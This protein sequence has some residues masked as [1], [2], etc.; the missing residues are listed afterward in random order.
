MTLRDRTINVTG[1]V[2]GPERNHQVETPIRERNR[3]G[4]SVDERAVSGGGGCETQGPDRDV[5]P[6]HSTRTPTE[7]SERRSVSETDLEN[8]P[9]PKR[10]P[11]DE[12]IA[13]IGVV[14]PEP[15][16]EAIHGPRIACSDT[17][18][19]GNSRAG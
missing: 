14:V 2:D 8:V 9:I 10:R 16:V 18:S 15:F 4:R 1:V 12:V 6:G 17:D 13:E 3:Q 5:E 7:F 11:R 19:V